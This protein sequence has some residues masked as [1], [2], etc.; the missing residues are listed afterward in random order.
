MRDRNPAASQDRT[1]LA[2]S[3]KYRVMT[4]NFGGRQPG[5]CSSPAKER[6]LL[7]K[8]GH[9]VTIILERCDV[10]LLQEVNAERA[11]NVVASFPGTWSTH[12]AR[13]PILLTCWNSDAMGKPMKCQ[14]C[15]MFP[16]PESW[17]SRWHRRLCQTN[18]RKRW[19]REFLANRRKLLAW[20]QRPPWAWCVFWITPTMTL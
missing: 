9:D 19:T 6:T 10:A 15:R 1:N 17:A 8:L 16:D 7:E 13:E 14:Q 11:R 20:R 3:R 2:A 5:F 18:F 12:Y 4:C